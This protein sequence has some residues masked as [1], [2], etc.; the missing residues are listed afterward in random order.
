[1]INPPQAGHYVPGRLH[2]GWHTRWMRRTYSAKGDLQGS[3]AGL[4]AMARAGP[5]RHGAVPA[6]EGNSCMARCR[7]GDASS[8]AL[9]R[10]AP[11]G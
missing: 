2:S 1:V 10:S 5:K 11:R 3:M 4:L 7:A 9:P 6:V 8:A